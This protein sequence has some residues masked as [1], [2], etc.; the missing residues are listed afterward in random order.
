MSGAT[1]NA[2]KRN[3]MAKNSKNGTKKD[4]AEEIARAVG[5]ARPFAIEA[6]DFN[7]PARP[8]TCLEVDFPIVPVNQVAKVESSS[9]A[10]RKPI[11]TM[12]KWWA[13]RK[14]WSGRGSVRT[15]TARRTRSW[16]L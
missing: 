16:K 14:V 9:G 4:L 2:T 8:K 15:S 13:R 7:D 5:A 12:S 10:G 6:V 1:R 3:A 11:Y